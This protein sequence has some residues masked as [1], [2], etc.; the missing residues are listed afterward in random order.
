MSGSKPKLLTSPLCCLSLAV[1]LRRSHCPSLG[2][3]AL[4]IHQ[5]SLFCIP[6]CVDWWWGLRQVQRCLCP[7][8]VR[9][10]LPVLSRDSPTYSMMVGELVSKA[11]ASP[12]NCDSETQ[13]GAHE[14]AFKETPR[15][16]QASTGH[17]ELDF[18]TWILVIQNPYEENTFFIQS[19]KKVF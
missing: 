14:T 1:W 8:G 18:C 9:Y 17:M 7:Q 3:S 11:G 12:R 19:L 5:G 15:G 4:L 10:L 13:G 16:F 6:T 2:L